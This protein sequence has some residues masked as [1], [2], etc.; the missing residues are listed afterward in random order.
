MLRFSKDE[1]TEI[2]RL[3]VLRSA[4]WFDK[5]NKDSVADKHPEDVF[6][7][8]KNQVGGLSE[9]KKRLLTMEPDYV[10]KNMAGDRGFREIAFYESL[11]DSANQSRKLD[12]QD[13][14]NFSEHC[15]AAS[16]AARFASPKT[17]RKTVQ[18]KE[19]REKMNNEIE[20][21]RRE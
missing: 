11:Y 5:G 9:N 3:A 21:L 20:L 10:L 18:R 8:L 14:S 15:S 19:E 6:P 13:S 7:T 16:S 4:L 1:K 17:A 2:L 12:S